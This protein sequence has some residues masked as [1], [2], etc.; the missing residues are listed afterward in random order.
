MNCHVALM[1]LAN[2]KAPGLDGIPVEVE[3]FQVSFRSGLVPQSCR[4]AV[5]TL[6]LKKGDLQDPKNWRPVLL[7][8]GD[9]KVL[10]NALALRLREVMP[11]V[12]H[13]DGTYYVPGRLII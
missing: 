10:S 9:Y 7:L 8:S 1:S 12:V 4:R 6:L 3:V 2:G 11:E 5:I 13:V